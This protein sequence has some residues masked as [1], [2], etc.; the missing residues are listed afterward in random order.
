MNSTSGATNK[1]T[2]TGTGPSSTTPANPTGSSSTTH[3]KDSTGQEESV[4]DTFFSQESRDSAQEMPIPVRKRKALRSLSHEPVKRTRKSDSGSVPPCDPSPTVAS[5]G[6]NPTMRLT[7]SVT[8]QYYQTHS[9]PA[10]SSITEPNS[11]QPTIL[12]YV[13]TPVIPTQPEGGTYASSGNEIEARASE[14]VRISN[15]AVG[16]TSSHQTSLPKLEGDVTSVESEPQ[17]GESVDDR[18]DSEFQQT[19]SSQVS[20]E[21]VS[22]RRYSTRRQDRSQGSIVERLTQSYSARIEQALGSPEVKKKP[23]QSPK[24]TPKAPKPTTV[25][26]KSAHGRGRRSRGDSKSKAIGGERGGVSQLESA[27]DEVEE[28]NLS[29]PSMSMTSTG[30]KGWLIL[31]RERTL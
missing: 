22:P 16:E 6:R 25:A 9:Q 8:P 17:K 4:M 15:I 20:V 7:R 30:G 31:P 3:A 29:Q 28:A 24:R 12:D 19:S 26:P 27:G 18:S 23:L 13:T 10:S 21:V 11:S 1:S 5:P 14:Q 2:A